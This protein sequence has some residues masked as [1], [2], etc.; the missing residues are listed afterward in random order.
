MKI[1]VIE[2]EKALAESIAAYLRKDGSVCELAQDY[3][4]A[5]LK[6]GVYEYDCV[7]VDIT[8]PGG[9]GL[10]LIRTLKKEKVSCGIIIISAKNSVDDKIDGL[11]LGADDYLSKP[12]NL[13]EL[14]A[15]IKSVIRR[16][17]FEGNEVITFNEIQLRPAER[18]VLIDSKPLTLT[19][20]EYDLLLFFMGNKDRIITKEAI[21][22][23]LWGDDIDK[24]DSFD[25]IYTHIKNLRKK[26]LAL[27]CKDYLNTAYGIGYKF[28]EV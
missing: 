5:Q 19:K 4:S 12:F 26:M 13:A 16:R 28:A 25:F 11:D 9:N 27:G 2:D 1:L 23:H 6:L 20:K 14:N 3:H 17:K 18:L 22:E 10:E 24:L 8:L 7:L 15:R 21:A